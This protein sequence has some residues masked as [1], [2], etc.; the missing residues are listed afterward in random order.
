MSR[1]YEIVCHDCREKLWIGQGWPDTR[2]YIY[3]DET[4]LTL[5]ERFLFAHQL[6]NLRFGDDEYLDRYKDFED[7]ADFE[8]KS[9]TITQT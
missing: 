6:H 1:T 5:L 2:V 8:E 7:Y 4:H 9:E 3:T